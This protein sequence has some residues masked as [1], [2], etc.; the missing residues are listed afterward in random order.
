MLPGMDILIPRIFALIPMQRQEKALP[1]GSELIVEQHGPLGDGL[2]PRRENRRSTTPQ[3]ANLRISMMQPMGLVGG[4]GAGMGAGTGAGTGTG[5]GAGAG[6]G[7]LETSVH[8]RTFAMRT[9]LMN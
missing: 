5:A 2:I 4:G 6:E 9:M 1:T 3:T 8:R 7:W